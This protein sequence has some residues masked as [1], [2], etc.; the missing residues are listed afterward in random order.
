VSVRREEIVD[1]A[2]RLFAQRGYTATSMREIADAAGVLSGS[3]Y[4]HFRSKAQ[5]LELAI[6]PFYDRL[7]P[8]QERAAG[9]DATGAARLEDMLR[10]TLAVCAA[11]STEIAILHYG[12]PYIRDVEDLASLVERSNKSLDLWHRVITAGV[13]DGS[14]RPTLHPETAGRMVTSAI[15]GVLDRQRYVTRPDLVREHTLAGLA[16][17]LVA[18]LTEGLGA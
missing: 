10:T 12:W 14:L 9:T 1:I 11:H 16:D 6:M 18:L 2:K 13:T 5:I 17:E 4:S 7:I 3:L 15:S 8:E